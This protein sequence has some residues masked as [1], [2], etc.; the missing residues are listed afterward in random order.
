MVSKR[1]EGE[2]EFSQNPDNNWR[3][4]HWQTI[5]YRQEEGVPARESGETL[6][7]V[8]QNGKVSEFYDIVFPP[9]TIP[10][11]DDD[12]AQ[13]LGE[14]YALASKFLLGGIP[15]ESVVA[16]AAIRYRE[17]FRTLISNHN[18]V[19]REKQLIEVCRWMMISKAGD[20]LV[21]GSNATDS[22]S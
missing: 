13:K 9:D 10:N 7:T 12:D 8:E 2:G 20:L 14:G 15:V 21:F 4:A 17:Q 22:F 18:S 3:R 1:K 6:L 19:D 11:G 16:Y 5:G